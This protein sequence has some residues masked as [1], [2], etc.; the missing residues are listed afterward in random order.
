MR[1]ILGLSILLAGLSLAGC[2]DGTKEA[3]NPST[4]P[5][6]TTTPPPD[7]VYEKGFYPLEKDD[8]AGASWRWMG[9]EGIVKVKNTK[10]DMTL[11]IA[12]NVPMD[13]F[14]QPPS[15]AI[16]INGE[17]LEKF[18]ATAGLMEKVYSVPAAKLG[19][20]D[21]AE[22]KITTTKAFTPKDSIKGATDPRALG[23]SLTNLTWQPK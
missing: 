20:S 7:I 11:K 18:N 16:S 10:K 5:G 14:P 6:T 9:N 4:S 21:F 1:K 15:I 12:G 19:S 13:R 8:K 2:A 3:V 22:I 23:F 17:E